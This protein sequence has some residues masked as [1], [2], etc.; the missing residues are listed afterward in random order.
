MIPLKR[1]ASANYKISPNIKEIINMIKSFFK[2]LNHNIYYEK[3]I[4]ATKDQ[5]QIITL[6]KGIGM[7]LI[8]GV[9][10]IAIIKMIIPPIKPN[11]QFLTPKIMKVYIKYLNQSLKESSLWS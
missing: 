3:S 2:Y 6:I 1:R 9:K 8:K 5:K 4:Q 11:T 10:Q 7:I